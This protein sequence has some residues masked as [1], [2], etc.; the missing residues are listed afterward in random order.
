MW[1]N[2]ISY[3]LFQFEP[4][5][6]NQ[7]EEIAITDELVNDLNGYL[8]SDRY[9]KKYTMYNDF[10]ITEKNL[11]TDV[12]M[13]L[14]YNYVNNNESYNFILL[15]DEEKN[16][17]YEKGYEAIY[18]IKI[19]DLEKAYK[20]VFGTKEKTRVNDFEINNIMGK[21]VSEDYF[22]I[23]NNVGENTDNYIIYKAIDTYMISNEG[24]ELTIFEYFVKC[25]KLTNTCYSDDELNMV[26]SKV[27]IENDEIK[28][29]DIKDVV[30]F[31]HVY[32]KDSN[33]NFY[34]FS[35]DVDEK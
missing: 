15:T 13:S 17:S 12:V 5:R 9:N 18:K 11:S 22:Y 29:N 35:T 4:E 19:S 31:K 6:K 21:K 2:I 10:Y 24:K 14:V 30:K 26:N 20:K 16:N 34:W 28:I 33:N 8:I 23:Y 3:N 25:D 27:T 32:K 1:F 7:R